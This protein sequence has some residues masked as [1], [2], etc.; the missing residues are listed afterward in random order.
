METTHLEDIVEVMGHVL[1]VW[2]VGTA[3]KHGENYLRVTIYITIST[4]QRTTTQRMPRGSFLFQILPTKSRPD[5][6][7]AASETSP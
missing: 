1:H 6:G 4:F 7:H 5:L 2:L 3:E